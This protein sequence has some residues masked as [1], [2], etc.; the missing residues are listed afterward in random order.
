MLHLLAKL[1]SSF[2]SPL[3][4]KTSLPRYWATAAKLNQ[5]QCLYSQTT[6]YSYI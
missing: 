1:L 4:T 5:S 6:N 3:N 2:P